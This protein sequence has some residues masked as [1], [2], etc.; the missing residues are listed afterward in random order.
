MVK[1]IKLYMIATKGTIATIIIT[2]AV[3]KAMM[4]MLT[5]PLFK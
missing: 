1:I 4:L 2:T 5:L 3:N